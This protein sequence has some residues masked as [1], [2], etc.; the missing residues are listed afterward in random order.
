MKTNMMTRILAAAA[1]FCVCYF[2][3][4]FFQPDKQRLATLR[5]VCENT[6]SSVLEA[7]YA[8]QRVVAQYAVTVFSA[9]DNYGY[10]SIGQVQH[11]G[12][13]AAFGKGFLAGYF[14]PLSALTGGV[15]TVYLLWN[16]SKAEYA[17]RAVAASY[18]RSMAVAIGLSL[19]AAAAVFVLMSR[20][21]RDSR[22]PR[23]IAQPVL[24]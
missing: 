9:L 4:G 5:A 15:K 6:S 22:Q 24:A 19:T 14:H 13:E 8:C 23:E 2:A 12:P 21:S 10:K 16:A 18:C 11:T 1:A 20:R 7:S 17:E 3:V